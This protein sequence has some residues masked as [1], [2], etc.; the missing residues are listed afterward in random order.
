MVLMDKAWKKGRPKK[1]GK[2]TQ[3]RA[4][5]DCHP[6][7]GVVYQTHEP[8]QTVEELRHRLKRS[9]RFSKLDMGHSFHQ[10]EI[11]EKVRKLFTFPIPMATKTGPIGLRGWLWGII[12]LPRNARNG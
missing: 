6:L 9:T 11:E 3:T 1:R 12:H 7:N 8:I 4:N 5:L 10:F 2:R